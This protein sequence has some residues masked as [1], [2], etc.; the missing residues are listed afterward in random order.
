MSQ[1]RVWVP[2]R[3]QGRLLEELNRHWEWDDPMRPDA[4]PLPAH[5]DGLVD[6]T[7]GGAGAQQIIWNA[8]MGGR[9]RAIA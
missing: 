4:P 2:D 1:Q 5:R 7:G 8:L 3:E 6:L 9:R